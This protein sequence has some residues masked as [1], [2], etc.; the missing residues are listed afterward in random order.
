MILDKE[1]KFIDFGLSFFSHK[2][3]DKAVDLH[4]LRQAL[5][6]KHFKIWVECYSEALKAYSKECKQGE[7]V[8]A[9]L[10]VVESR[11]RYKHK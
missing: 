8:I 11:G 3:E 2:E 10:E 4:L 9:R 7:E 1:I 6:S 5:E